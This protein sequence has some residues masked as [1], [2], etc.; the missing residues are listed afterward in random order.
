MY[1]FAKVPTVVIV[2]DWDEYNWN[3]RGCQLLNINNEVFKTTRNFEILIVKYQISPTA[4][5]V[6]ILSTGM[7]TVGCSNYFTVKHLFWL[8]WVNNL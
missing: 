2:D 8:N 6:N 1:K 7:H 3:L 4:V 5:V